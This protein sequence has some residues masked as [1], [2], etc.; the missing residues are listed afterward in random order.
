MQID[1]L[2]LKLAKPAQRAIQG[3]GI[4][5]LEQLANFSEE[6]ILGL[7]GIGDNA[8]QI[9]KLILGS[10]RGLDDHLFSQPDNGSIISFQ[11]PIIDLG[12][13]GSGLPFQ[14]VIL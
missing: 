3:A 1:I 14:K 12:K 13:A 6:E 10:S 2:L 7:H 5:T 4:T 11:L 8:M 9:I